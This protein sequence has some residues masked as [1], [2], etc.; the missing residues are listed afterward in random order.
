MIAAASAASRRVSHSAFEPTPIGIAL[1]DDDERRRR[2]SRRPRWPRRPRRIIAAS[3]SGS[4]QRSG[5]GARRSALPA[6]PGS[7]GR[8]ARRPRRNAR[9]GP[10]WSTK[11]QIVTPQSLRAAGGTRRP[12][13]PAARSSGPRR[14]RARRGC[15]RV[16]YLM[17]PARSAWPGRASVIG[18]G[19][20]AQPGS[21]LDRHPLLPARPVA[22]RDREGEGRAERA[23]EAQARGPRHAVLLDEHPPA[24]AVAVLA[25]DRGP[26]S[27]FAVETR[28]PRRQPVEDAAQ[29]GPVRFAGGQQAQPSQRHRLRP[30]IETA[31]RSS[32][33]PGYETVD[34]R[35]DR[36]L[37]T[38]PATP[39]SA[40]IANAIAMRWS[41][42]VRIAASRAARRVARRQP[43]G[44]LLRV[45][46]DRLQVVD[47]ER[48]PV[49]L[50]DA[51][52]GGVAQLA[53]SV[54]GR[55]RDRQQGQLVDE[56]G[57][58]GARRCGSAAAASARTH[59]DRADR[60]G[61]GVVGLARRRP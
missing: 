57:H 47:D 51:Q 1:G 44:Q 16:S 59:V 21:R 18:F 52:L 41:P 2:S 54:R 61:R 31:A 25:A 32:Q 56:V 15:R 9:T 38:A 4:G 50:L 27:T 12:P 17:A 30:R 28:R 20:S 8:P 45:D 49:R 5:V 23:P 35:R 48:D 29:A 6:S 37:S 55:H 40:A 26:R 3:A 10:S 42:A 13:R 43:S 58:A 53:R 36:R 46:A 24:A 11:L 22:V 33:K 19:R 39:V 7:R 34:A 60:L 14:A